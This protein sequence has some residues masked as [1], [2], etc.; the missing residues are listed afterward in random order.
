LLK[1]YA[2]TRSHLHHSSFADR[3][4]RTA[5]PCAVGEILRDL[6]FVG[7]GY[8]C[9]ST[10][11]VREDAREWTREQRR[12]YWV[13]FGYDEKGE[14]VWDWTADEAA[15]LGQGYT[16]ELDGYRIDVCWY[17][18]GDGTLTFV[19]WRGG[20]ILRSLYNGDC[21]KSNRWVDD[22]HEAVPK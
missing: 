15:D 5:D 13:A 1:V 22:Q 20:E 11:E 14:E 17:W 9:Y 3:I 4:L 18:D 12:D 8:G 21:K 7:E 16:Y 6:T 19:V 2:M 10:F